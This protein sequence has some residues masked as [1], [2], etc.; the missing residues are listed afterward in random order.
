MPEP[1]QEKRLGKR[2]PIK[3]VVAG[4][5]RDGGEFEE[6]GQT[7]DVSAG[8]VFFYTSTDVMPNSPIDLLMPLPPQLA[9]RREVWVLCKGEVAR[10]E[11]SPDGRKGVGVLIQSYEMVPEA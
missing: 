1:I 3:L 11:P 6:I 7:R 9:D 8:G 5:A 2:L 10:I 4:R